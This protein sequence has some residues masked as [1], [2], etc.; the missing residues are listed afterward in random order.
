VEPE[1]A[2]REEEVRGRRV[3]AMP[4]SPPHAERHF[5]LDYVLG[6]RIAEGYV[7]ATDL[8]TRVGPRSNFATDTCIRRVGVDPS[9]GA[10]WLEELAFEVVNE[11]SLADINERAEDLSERGV[12]RL[13][14][15]FV[16][17]GEV[18]EWEP[19]QRRW[20][21]LPPEGELRDPTLHQP[22]KIRALLD[23]AAADDAVA[24]ALVAKGNPVIGKVQAEVLRRSIE[25]VCDRLEIPTSAEQRATLEGMSAEALEEL[26]DRLLLERRWP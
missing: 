16:K 26:H 6:P 18:R 21:V 25:R 14:A 13:V 3:V 23:A 15:I 1:S 2:A 7:A 11:Q 22:L 19:Q 4:A 12:R 8:L 5:G 20:R 24:E 17:A 9:T 10:R